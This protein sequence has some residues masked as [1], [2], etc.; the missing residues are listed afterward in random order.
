MDS[1][2]DYLFK[3]N[4]N[5]K[6]YMKLN[7]KKAYFSHSIKTYNTIDEEEEFEFLQ[8]FFNGN[9]ICPNNHS[10]L[11]VNES[12]Y[13]DIFRLV[14]VLIVSE[15]NGYV[16]KGSFKDCETA[17]RKGIPIYLIERNGSSFNFRL[18]V[19]FVEVS[20]FNPIEYGNLV[21]ISLD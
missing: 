14:D 21:S 3:N 7:G 19:D 2:T 10:H 8:N 4:F 16:G 5:L 6:L 20:N 9:I 13:T 17:Y 15:Y 11:F 18:V 12:D 1:K